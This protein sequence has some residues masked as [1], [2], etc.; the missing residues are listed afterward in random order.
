MI[1]P[2]EVTMFLLFCFNCSIKDT[3]CCSTSDQTPKD[4]KN[5]ALSFRI[6]IHVKV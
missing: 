2:Q 1:Q 5:Q 4:R 6:A 3:T